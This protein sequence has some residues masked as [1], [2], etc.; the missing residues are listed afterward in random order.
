MSPFLRRD[1]L[2]HN[3]CFICKVIY[4]APLGTEVCKYGHIQV[5]LANQNTGWLFELDAH[6][7]LECFQ[8]GSSG[9]KVFDEKS[10]ST[11]KE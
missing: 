3:K 2:L 6:M 4:L 5:I 7:D 11:S 8:C 10:I 9:T 1:R